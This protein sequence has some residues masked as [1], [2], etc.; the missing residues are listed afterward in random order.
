M[1]RLAIPAPLHAGPSS[2]CSWRVGA[3]AADVSVQR[4]HPFLSR[5]VGRHQNKAPAVTL[6]AGPSPHL[7]LHNLFRRRCGRG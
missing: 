2:H 6:A 1:F 5:L 7:G 4:Y 3:P